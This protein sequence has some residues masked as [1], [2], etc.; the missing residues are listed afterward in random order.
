MKLSN[1]NGE[2]LKTAW[3]MLPWTTVGGRINHGEK[4]KRERATKKQ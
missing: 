2:Q 1:T 4:Q 3:M